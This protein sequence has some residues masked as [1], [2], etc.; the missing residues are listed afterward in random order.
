[1]QRAQLSLNTQ[2]PQF[3]LLGTHCKAPKLHN[4]LIKVAGLSFGINSKASAANSFGRSQGN[5]S[6]YIKITRQY[7]KHIPSTTGT[8]S[9]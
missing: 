2:T 8:T 9:L 7:Q 6:F 4:R 5:I 1:L 3:G